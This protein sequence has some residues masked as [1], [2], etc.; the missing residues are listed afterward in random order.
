MEFKLLVCCNSQKSWSVLFFLL[1]VYDSGLDFHLVEV[2]QGPC[3]D[4]AFQLLLILYGFH[5]KSEYQSN[6]SC[7]CKCHL[8]SY[9]VTPIQKFHA[10]Q[11]EKVTRTLF[12]LHSVFIQACFNF[13]LTLSLFPPVFT[14][15]RKCKNVTGIII[16][17]RNWTADMP[18]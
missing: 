12:Q 9:S 17:A 11:L 8:L 7:V 10:T 18:D 15:I 3:A 4:F 2:P 6:A 13:A 1:V 5:L 14:F 16:L